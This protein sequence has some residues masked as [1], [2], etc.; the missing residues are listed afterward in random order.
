[1]AMWARKEVR[2]RRAW[3]A[4]IEARVRMGNPRL[5]MSA[6]VAATAGAGMLASAV[7]HQVG[8]AT[9]AVRYGLSVVFAYLVFMFIIWMWIVAKRRSRIDDP[10][11]DRGDLPDVAD[12]A[13]GD[14]VVDEASDWSDPPRPLRRRY[15]LDLP[16]I[17]VDDEGFVVFVVVAAIIA[18]GAASLYTVIIAPQLLS[19]VLLDGVLATVIYRRLR[20]DDRRHWLDSA[21]A[22]TW[23][24]VMLVGIF[25]VIAGAVG[26]WYA[27]E[28]TTLAEVLRHKP[29][30]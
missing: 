26:Q 11:H 29:A 8:L 30:P 17:G 3:L 6:M 18:A 2:S 4:R 13:D 9:L 21:L 14:L 19:E 10:G 7:L 16:D 20:A 27:P 23:V 5:L 28:A 15:R 22:R 24:P 1:M 25:F 12:P